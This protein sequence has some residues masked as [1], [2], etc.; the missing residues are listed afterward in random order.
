MSQIK[1]IFEVDRLSYPGE[2]RGI[3][4]YLEI[5]LAK[6]LNN[7][8]L[9]VDVLSSTDHAI[10]HKIYQIMQSKNPNENLC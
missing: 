3:R 1:P 9:G 4:E 5:L 7:E 10:K 8:G 6:S 2:D